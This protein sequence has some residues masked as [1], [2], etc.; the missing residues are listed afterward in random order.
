MNSINVKE[1]QLG[2]I[3]TEFPLLNQ[4]FFQLK[5]FEELWTMIKNKKENFAKWYNLSSIFT[6][7][8]EEIEKDVK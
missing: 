5:P 4:T 2:W 1:E 3:L 8:P 6:L 7:E